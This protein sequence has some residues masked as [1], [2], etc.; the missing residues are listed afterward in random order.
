MLCDREPAKRDAQ[1]PDDELR[2]TVGEDASNEGIIKVGIRVWWGM[3]LPPSV[4]TMI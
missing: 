1:G 4:Q 2:A 3:F